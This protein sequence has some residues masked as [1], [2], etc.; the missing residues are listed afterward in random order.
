MA[1][2]KYVTK[3]CH[4]KKSDAKKAQK[5]MH[6]KGMT[7]TVVKTK[8]GKRVKYCVKSAGKRK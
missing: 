3:S 8:V 6:N 1:K 5:Y 2:R 4:N 7:A